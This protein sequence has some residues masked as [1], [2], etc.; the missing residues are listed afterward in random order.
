MTMQNIN[1]YFTWKVDVTAL[2]KE[3]V[4]GVGFGLNTT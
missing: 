4:V 2:V 3:Q 1:N